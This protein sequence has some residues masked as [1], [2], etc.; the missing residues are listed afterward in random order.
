MNFTIFKRMILLRKLCRFYLIKLLNAG[1]LIGSQGAVQN[2]TI[3]LWGN[4]FFVEVTLVYNI[5]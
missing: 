1:I 5:I 4:F 2:V 3:S